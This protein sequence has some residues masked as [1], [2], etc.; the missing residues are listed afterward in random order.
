MQNAACSFRFVAMA[1][2]LTP[3]FLKHSWEVLVLFLIPI[4]G[5]IPAGVVVAQH[6][7][8][9]WSVTMVLYAISDVILACLFEPLMLL[10]LK[11]SGHSPWFQKFRAALAKST[12]KTVARYG[13][14]PGPFALIMITFGT[15]PMT[16]RSVAKAAGHGFITGWALTIAGDMLF[17]TVLM[18]ST[19]WLNHVL[20]DGTL[21][22]L[23]ITLA[24]VFFPSIVKKLRKRTCEKTAEKYSLS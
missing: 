17:F 2:V 8:L 19:L 9:H 3:A 22:A 21:A 7:G 12:N 13:I 11:M 18:V 1:P 23:V 16:G 6:Y 15:D 10:F 24:I 14:K 20:G 5:G 4:G